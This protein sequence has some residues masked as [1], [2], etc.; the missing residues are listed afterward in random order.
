MKLL[1]CIPLKTGG[2]Y[3]ERI[4]TCEETWL[5]GVEVVAPTDL[6]MELVSEDHLIRQKR[7]KWFCA[8]ALEHGYDYLF[9][10]DSDAYVRI[11]ELLK[12][13]FEQHDYM[14]WHKPRDIHAFASVGYFLSRK[15][16]QLVVD[17]DHW[18]HS[19]GNYWG[20]CW[21]GEVLKKSGIECHVDDRFVDGQ[22]KDFEAAPEGEWISIH[23]VS[24]EVM[25]K[26]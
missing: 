5:K 12:C 25:R 24:N 17:A 21:V 3:F 20:D 6:M 7:M 8:Y 10:V 13:G 19:S 2:E 1:L 26:I 9:R 18:A 14:G 11:P 16:M 22:G 4:R 15:A 23:P